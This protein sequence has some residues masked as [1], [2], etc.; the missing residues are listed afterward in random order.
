MALLEIQWHPDHRQLRGFGMICVVVFVAL[1]AWVRLAH[2]VVWLEVEPST[3]QWVATFFWMAAAACG[4]LSVVAPTMLRPLYLFLTV[5][6]LPVGFVIAHVVM[7][8]VFFG[9]FTPI[10]IVFR[11]IGRDALTRRFDRNAST[12]WVPR[13]GTRS[14]NQYF[15]QF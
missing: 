8:V 1:G 6:G 2:A 4:G 9:L 12:Y 3:A 14:A 11:L 13:P 15:R 10:G 5:I 7:A